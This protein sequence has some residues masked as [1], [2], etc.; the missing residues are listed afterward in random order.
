MGRLP[1]LNPAAFGASS[2]APA[3]AAAGAVEAAGMDMPPLSPLLM[4]AAAAS[5]GEG[6][7]GGGAV[8]SRNAQ[9][10][11]AMTNFGVEGEAPPRMASETGKAT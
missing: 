5:V 1:P 3:S 4:G 9:G 10:G 11:R 6:A 7:I 2:V 8:D